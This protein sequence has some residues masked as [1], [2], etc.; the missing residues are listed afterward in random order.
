MIRF[1]K[2]KD[3]RKGREVWWPYQ[4]WTRWAGVLAITACATVLL[5]CQYTVRDIGFVD[6]R[7]P[8]YTL[9]ISGSLV[10]ENR[11]VDR[12]AQAKQALIE[13]LAWLR[14]TPCQLMFGGQPAN[15]TQPTPDDDVDGW[16][17]ELVDRKSRRHR[18][19][20]AE[21]A[22]SP[23]ELAARIREVFS[24]PVMTTITTD[25]VD[26]FAQLVVVLGNDPDANQAIQAAAQESKIAI[27]RIEPMLPRPLAK[28]VAVLTISAENRSEESLLLWALGL[29]YSPDAQAAVAVIYGRGKLA[30]PVVTSE[31]LE[32][33]ELLA[34]LALIG[35]SCECET[36]RRWN[37]QPVIPAHWSVEQRRRAAQ[38]LG[39]DPE[40]PL[41]R[42][43]VV[44]IVGRGPTS[45]Q[46]ANGRA[47]A[48]V[49]AIEQLLLGYRETSL[50]NSLHDHTSGEAGLVAESSGVQTTRI[51]GDG[52]DFDADDP[53]ETRT[54]IL[55]GLPQDSDL[56][57]DAT[58][59]RVTS[60]VV[61]IGAGLLGFALLSVMLAI[62]VT[63]KQ[64][65]VDVAAN[66]DR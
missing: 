65:P 12:V 46:A 57:D 51:L 39:F 25:A 8:E 19:V 34:Q 40:S 59:S 36:D 10:A 47:A 41:V 49:D 52:W 44:R 38:S 63:R 43:E 6:L 3:S 21:Q 7:G 64:E 15:G 55:S 28:P 56:P 22:C 42:A 53:V 45:G 20:E 18:L 48:G 17:V 62:V 24:T 16:L 50:G 31:Q 9:V 37:D 66:S 32:N 33:R 30:G 13:Q 14:D 4:G 1:R 26:S 11:S 27:R 35:E 58:S 61:L 2:R 29:E 60:P 23:A 54:Q 5:A